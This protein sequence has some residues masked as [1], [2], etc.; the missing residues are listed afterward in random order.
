MTRMWHRGSFL[1]GINRQ[2]ER[3]HMF[4]LRRNQ[5]LKMERT[6]KQKLTAGELQWLLLLSYQDSIQTFRHHTYMKKKDC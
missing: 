4:M 2:A 3:S 1:L 6:D 5:W